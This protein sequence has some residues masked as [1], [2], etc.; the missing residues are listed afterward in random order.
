[1]LRN[2]Q[3]I[4]KTSGKTKKVTEYDYEI[5]SKLNWKNADTMIHLERVLY[6]PETWTLRKIFVE[7]FLEL[8]LGSSEFKINLYNRIRNEKS[9]EENCIG[10]ILT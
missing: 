9:V 4:I 3:V 2:L 8:E 5:K 6:G 7:L 1:M 10:T